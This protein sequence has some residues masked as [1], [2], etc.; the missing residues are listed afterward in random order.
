MIS[1]QV[2]NPETYL[3][4][5]LRRHHVPLGRFPCAAALVCC[6]PPPPVGAWAAHPQPAAAGAGTR[7]RDNLEC[8]SSGCCRAANASS[9]FAAS[10][11]KTY[12]DEDACGEGLS[13]VA[14][15]QCVLDG[16][17]W[18]RLNGTRRAC[19]AELLFAR[20][21]SALPWSLPAGPRIHPWVSACDEP[22]A[23]FGDALA[24]AR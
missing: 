6:A 8:F 3:A 18:R 23:P 13:A 4:L 17:T 9:P 21:T 1:P 2:H 24:P 14:Q 22:C 7:L 11:F 16:K 5:H 10:S 15:A 12:G 19:P 20:W